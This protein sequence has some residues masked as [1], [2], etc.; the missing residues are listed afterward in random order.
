MSVVIGAA[1]GLLFLIVTVFLACDL[2]DR[3]MGEK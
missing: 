3:L 1:F 2:I